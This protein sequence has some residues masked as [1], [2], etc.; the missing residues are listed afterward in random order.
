MAPGNLGNDQVLYDRLDSSVQLLRVLTG[1]LSVGVPLAAIMDQNLGCGKTSL[2]WKFRSVLSANG[3]TIPVPLRDAVYL[4]I[5]VNGCIQAEELKALNKKFI[6]N[7]TRR[8]R[9]CSSIF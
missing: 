7:E 4:H 1:A 2:G 5:K 8:K 6:G 9:V 3:I